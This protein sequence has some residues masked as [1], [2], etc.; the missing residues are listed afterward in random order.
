MELDLLIRGGRVVDGTGGAAMTADVGVIG[1]RIV[2]VEPL[3]QA[4]AARIVDATDRIVAP[5]FID[6]HVHSELVLRGELPADGAILQGVTTHAT[7]ADGFGWAPLPAEDGR[8]LWRSTAFAYG[9]VDRPVS[10]P[11]IDSYL[12]GL[13]GSPLNAVPYAPHGAIRF[14]VMGWQRRPASSDELHRMRNLTRQWMDAGAVGLAAGLDYEPGMSAPTAELIEL[15][16]VVAEYGGV[17]APHQRYIEAGRAGAW[18]ESIEIARASGV[19]LTIAHEYVDDETDP[20]VAAGSDVDLTVDWYYYPAGSTHLLSMLPATEHA[21]GPDGLLQRLDAPDVRRRIGAILEEGLLAA[22][23]EGDRLYF[24]TTRTGLHVGRTIP[25][26]AA[27]Q[28]RRVAE[29]AVDLLR[30][31]LPVAVLV[32]RRGVPEVTFAETIR[33]TLAHPSWSVASDGLYHGALPHPRGYGCF[34]RLLGVAV[35]ELGAASLETVI[36]KM[37]GLAADRLRLADRGR[38]RPG[39]AADLVVFDPQTIGDRATWEMPRETAVGV[40]SVAVNG[41]LVVDEGRVT[42]LA[43]G[44]RLA[45]R[46][47]R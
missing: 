36:H 16:R 20:I 38:I 13:A 46:T 10:W 39:L 12:S 42:G 8:A 15:C 28:G 41:Q 18:T 45:R 19:A 40:D 30:A 24:S 14:A 25:E 34:A 29:T 44:R 9:D 2:A 4:S 21:G 37:T 11:T 33:R 7:S 3:P 22:E 27:D 6:G 23:A 17:Y 26:I 5:G 1:D 31:E 47:G 35:R 43:P 32:Y